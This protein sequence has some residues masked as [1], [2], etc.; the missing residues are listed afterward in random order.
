MIR[1]YSQTA[2]WLKTCVPAKTTAIRLAF[3]YSSIKKTWYK[4]LLLQ[5]S[6][7]KFSAVMLV[8]E[9]C[10]NI[11]EN[12]AAPPFRNSGMHVPLS[13]LWPQRHLPRTYFPPKSLMGAQLSCSL[14]VHVWKSDVSVWA[15]WSAHRF[16]L[17][18]V[19][20]S[21]LEIESSRQSWSTAPNQGRRKSVWHT[22]RLKSRRSPWCCPPM[23]P[24]PGPPAERCAEPPAWQVPGEAASGPS[25]AAGSSD[26]GT[27]Y[28]EVLN[29]ATCPLL[30]VVA[31]CY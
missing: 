18:P 10:A 1:S 23:F 28:L 24:G 11:S 27:S 29:G 5:S 21:G 7:C 25:S 30:S 2:V 17:G 12:I 14:L 6:M 31:P 16:W 15:T 22:V 20:T 3:M 9:V 4:F 19:Q 26:P 13:A 8:S